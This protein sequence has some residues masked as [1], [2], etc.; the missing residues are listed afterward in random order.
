MCVCKHLCVYCIFIRKCL[1]YFYT[2]KKNCTFTVKVNFQNV[3]NII[4][5][6][7]TRTA[8][9]ENYR[10]C[11]LMLEASIFHRLRKML[12]WVSNQFNNLVV[13]L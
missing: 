7:E 12:W 11:E 3:V 2:F 6:M 1:N 10:I 8:E 9:R 13:L 5:N 4:Q